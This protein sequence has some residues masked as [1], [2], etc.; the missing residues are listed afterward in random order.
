MLTLSGWNGDLYA[1]EDRVFDYYSGRLTNEGCDIEIGLGWFF[2]GEYPAQNEPYAAHL[3]GGDLPAA[4]DRHWPEYCP[5]AL[6]TRPDSFDNM[7][8]AFEI[9]DTSVAIGVEY[10]Y[11]DMNE[12]DAEKGGVSD[13]NLIKLRAV[14]NYRPVIENIYID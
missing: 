11:D 13:E 6:I 2:T 8:T 14:E 1:D 3:R 5:A 9:R 12:V 10:E 7:I 4:E